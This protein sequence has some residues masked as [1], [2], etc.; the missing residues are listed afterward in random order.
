MIR[1]LF[2]SSLLDIFDESLFRGCF[3]LFVACETIALNIF[4]SS[5]FSKNQNERVM[6][7]ASSNRRFLVRTSVIEGNYVF[8][9]TQELGLYYLV[10]GMNEVVVSH[11]FGS[12]D[13]CECMREAF[14]ETLR[15]GVG[16][17]WHLY[18]STR[19]MIHMG[20]PQKTRGSQE[21]CSAAQRGLRRPEP[22]P[23]PTRKAAFAS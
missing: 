11:L 6:Y 20:I 3:R 18:F 14:V 16:T 22:P 5:P 9:D 4:H 17:L 21:P 13:H 15:R 8:N 2:P 10:L 23:P 7:G 1:S 12:K 19:V